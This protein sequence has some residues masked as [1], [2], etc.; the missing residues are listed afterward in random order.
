ME[1]NNVGQ[2]IYP[3][4]LRK[5]TG[6]IEAWSKLK[7]GHYKI[8][9]FRLRIRSPNF[10]FS[11]CFPSRV[12]A[13][14]ELIK[15]NI[16]NKLEIKN[17][18]RDC[19]DHYKVKLSN[20]KEFLADKVDLHFIEAHIWCCDNHNYVICRPNK[21]QIKFHNLILGHNLTSNLT[22]DHINWD[23]LDNRRS[24]LRITTI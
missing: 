9:S 16:E 4:N 15:Q 19:G 12:E 2:I 3:Q 6:H 21:R 8:V 5:Y 10:K 1:V 14:C 24:N 18:M 17:T 7:D 20:G 11:K 22:I 23:P 13:K